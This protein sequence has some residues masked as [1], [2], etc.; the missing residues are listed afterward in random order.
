VIRVPFSRVLSGRRWLEIALDY[1][2]NLRCLGCHACH[3]TGE[4]LASSEALAWLRA[5]REAGIERL[6]LGGGEP[7]LRGDLVALVGAARQLGYA[8]IAV[9]SNGMRLAYPEYVAALLA[10]GVTEVRLNVKSH[11]SEIHDRLSGED[12]CHALMLQALALLQK[13]GVRVL[14]DVLLT[15]GTG[16]D[17]PETVSFF[18]E[19][20]VA[21]FTLWLLSAADSDDP[22]VSGAVPRIGDLVPHLS[23]ACER[24]RARGVSIESLHTPPCTLPADLRGLH[25]PAASLALVVVDPTSRAFA[26][27]TSSFEGGARVDACTLCSARERCGGPRADYLR[28]HG[29]SEFT[30]LTPLGAK[31]P[32]STSGSGHVGGEPG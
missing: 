31:V 5:G 19:R 11:R 1:R 2:C 29:G 12:G 27:E 32:S 7:T 22:A 3:D 4:R 10:A 25:R 9:Q 13:E 26:L 23:A 15:R 21:G 16:E 28:I 20:G 8:T 18:A 17:L 30:A 14:A 6:W 24:A